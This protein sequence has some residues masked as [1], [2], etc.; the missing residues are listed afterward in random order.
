MN[1]TVSLILPCY[2]PIGNWA[3]R[4]TDIVAQLRERIPIEEVIVV[5]DGSSDDIEQGL[6]NLKNAVEGLQYIS[7]KDNRGKGYA[8]R[9]GIRL[10]KGNKIIYTD[11]DFPYTVESMYAVYNTLLNCDIA[12]G[13]KDAGYYKRMPAMRKHISNMLRGMT[14]RLLRMNITDTQCG[15]KGLNALT[16]QIW[17]D[18]KVDGYLFE[19][20]AV[21]NAEKAGYILQPVP[22]ML[23]DGVVFSSIKFAVLFKELR[24]FVQIALN[25]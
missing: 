20:E 16:K 8:V 13:V 12:I 4:L 23:R 10:S 2:N 5:N 19:L 3:E 15:L 25:R 17:L 24:Y 7:Y 14:Q 18:G 21:R 9:A 6:R 1:D 11:I 22:V